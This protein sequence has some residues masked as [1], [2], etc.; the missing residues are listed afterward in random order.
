MI[1]FSLFSNFSN[2][3]ARFSMP[4]RTENLMYSFNLGP[5]H[6]IAFSTEVYYFINYG[7]KTLVNQYEWLEQDLIEA[8][9]PENRLV[10]K[11]LK[12]FL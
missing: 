8:N 6:F 2:Y 1:R 5:V 10:N 9:R 7:I 3:R 12:F 11:T 4:H